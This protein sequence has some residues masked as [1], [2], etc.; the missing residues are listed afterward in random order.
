MVTTRVRPPQVSDSQRSGRSVLRNW[1]AKFDV[2]AT[3]YLFIAPFFILFITFG[4]FPL[5]YNLVVSFRVWRLDQPGKNGW[6]GMDNYVRLFQDPD[7]FR[8][9]GNTFGLFFVSAI[10]QLVLALV[11]AG[12]L[13]R[14]LRAPTFWRM[15]VLLP[16]V[17]SIVASTLIFANVFQFSAAQP[18]A[19]L[20]NFILGL[21]HLGPVDWQASRFSSW[22]AIAIMVDWRWIGYNTLIYLASMQAVPRDLYEAASIDGAGSVRQFISIT[23]PMIRPAVIFTVILS[24]VGSLQLFTEPLMFDSQPA[25]ANGGSLGQFQTIGVLIY[26]VGW[27]NLNL[28]YA[29]AMS[30]VL[31]LIIVIVAAINAFAAHRMGG[32]R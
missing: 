18:D 16:Y 24:T 15:G 21:F 19:G 4:L 31:F 13:N 11:L 1:R 22:I 2:K 28:G 10:P 26:K 8:A 17:T 5:G 9:L 12:L 6:A 7:F 32:S 25:S 14:K 20:A 30:W 27:K 23:V 29:A 3:P